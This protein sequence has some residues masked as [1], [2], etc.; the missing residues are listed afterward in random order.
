MV[1]R[2]SPTGAAVYNS[3][4]ASTRRRSGTTSATIAAPAAHSPPMPSDATIRN[5]TSIAM[6][7]AAAQAAV[8]TAYI[9]IVNSSVR[10]RP[11]RSATRPK[12][13]P[14]TAQPTSRIDVSTPVHRS[15]AAEAAAV[16]SGMR[17]SVGTQLGA[18]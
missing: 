7:G 11:M 13:M 16:P 10:V 17:S 4:P 15:V 2:K 6:F 12:M 1:A 18:T 3:A 14:P 5:S 8:P 9:D